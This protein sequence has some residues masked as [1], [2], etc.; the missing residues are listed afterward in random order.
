M[1][2]FELRPLFFSSFDRNKRSNAR[3]LKSRVVFV[4]DPENKEFSYVESDSCL[5][6]SKTIIRMCSV[7]L[8]S[9]VC[10]FLVFCAFKL[11]HL[12]F[13]IVYFNNLDLA[14]LTSMLAASRQ[15]SYVCTLSNSWV[16]RSS[17]SV[18][19]FFAIN[20]S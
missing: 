4:G 10:A 14:T 17:C 19:T 6:Y 8:Q 12:F 18:R 20:L 15:S 13:A 11:E 2:R 1:Q 3:V 5:P 7:E 16:R 9:P